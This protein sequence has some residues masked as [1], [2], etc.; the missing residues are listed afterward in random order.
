M[1]KPLA[2]VTGA[3]SGIG[4]A[5]ALELAQRGHDLILVARREGALRDLA[6]TLA[7]AHRVTCHVIPADLVAPDGVSSLLAA[8][9]QRA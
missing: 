1:T 4:A 7:S 5:I 8:L 9:T 3:S 2:L 6:Q